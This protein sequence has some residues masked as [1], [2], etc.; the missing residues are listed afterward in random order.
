M[1]STSA[2]EANVP[3][4][5][6]DP[7]EAPLVGRSLVEASAGTGKTYAITTLLLRLVVEEGL[8]LERVL[9]V[10]FTEAAT[11]ELRDR[12]RR[13]L[14]EALLAF[15][16]GDA[17]GDPALAALLDRC[18]DREQGRRR[19]AVASQSVDLASIS[20][21][22]GFCH[23]VL[24]DSAFDSG[25][26]FDL[27]VVADLQTLRDE[28]ISDHW[29]RRV[30]ADPTPL[31][32]ALAAHGVRPRV[33]RGLVERAISNP[34]LQI[35][36]AVAAE[37]ADDAWR[38]SFA[39]ALAQARAAWDESAVLQCLSGPQLYKSR[40][41]RDELP[42]WC[43][44][45][46]RYLKDPPDTPVLPE[47][48][49]K[50]GA[51]SMAK[52]VYKGQ[53][54][55]EHPFFGAVDRLQAASTEFAA[56]AREQAIAFQHDLVEW[57]RFEVP[58]RAEE[59]GVLSFDDLL[60]QVRAA[61]RGRSGE[62]LARRL[63][64]RWPAALV[65]EFQDTDPIQ[66][67]IVDRAFGASRLFLVGDPKQAIYSFRGADV[68]AYLRAVDATPVERRFTM[69]HNWRS[70][71]TLVA[72][73]NRLFVRSGGP[74]PPFLIDGIGYPEVTAQ[75]NAVDQLCAPEPW[76]SA[77]FEILFQPRPGSGDGKD[78]KDSKIDR[79]YASRQVPPLVATEIRG[80]LDSGASVGER[81]LTA[82]D[83]AVLT[84]T[85]QQAFDVQDAL[86]DVGIKSV[87]LGDKSVFGSAEAEELHRVLR[88]VAEPTNTAA[89]RAA[90]TT[91]LFG[92]VANDLEAMED[93]G[94]A[95]EGWVR[96][97]RDWNALWV[98]RGFVQMFRAMVAGR[99]VQERL[100]RFAD[101]ERR[102]TNLLHL[103]ELLHTASRNE[104]LGPVGL[105]H[106]FATQRGLEGYASEAAQ[107]R[108]ESDE[109]AVRITTVHRA[110]GLEYDVVYCP[111]LWDGWL[112]HPA[113]RRALPFHDPDGALTVDIDPERRD[114]SPAKRVA[115]N[116]KLAES[117]R[118]LYVA[119]TRARHRC[120]VLWG[121]YSG[122]ATSA[123][124]Y[125]LHPPKAWP[126]TEADAAVL[127]SHLQALSDGEIREH[128]EAVVAAS[129]GGIAV[130]ELAV[131][132]AERA[133]A[134]G[135]S[136]GAGGAAANATLAARP[137]RR[138]LDR[139]PRLA[140]FTQMV[141]GAPAEEAAER[142]DAA[143]ATAELVAAAAAADQRGPTV[144]LAGMPRG[145]RVGNFF[146]DVLEHLDFA[147]E[148]PAV[149]AVVDDKLRSH[150]LA[151]DEWGAAACQ[152]VRDVL[153]TPLDLD[154]RP[155]RLCDVPAAQRHAELAFHLPVSLAGDDAPALQPRR[156]AVPFAQHPSEALP[157][158]YA[159][160]L[161]Q[162]GFPAIRG[163]LK[164]FIDLLFAVDGRFYVVDYKT[165][166]LGEQQED[167]ARARLTDAM[168][169]GDYFLQYHLYGVAVHRHLARTVPAY[170]YD[171]NFGGA[172]YLFVRG[173]T[174]AR[175]MATGVFFERPPRARIEALS[176]VLDGRDA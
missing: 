159:E 112:L 13:R 2:S 106:W 141:R 111:Y 72:A 133:S 73:V 115:E 151:P 12:V 55:P 122:S 80:L 156:L 130:R 136:G 35:A 3:L 94:A 152:G 134:V 155:T 65:D 59:R 171:R 146:H 175:G 8:E 14:R 63:S 161:A 57:A 147:A 15:S 166:F 132:P 71:P 118:L 34:D 31:A 99:A 87:V 109:R 119:V 78:A 66:Y 17:G 41:P 23:R 29:L 100:L 162:L 45:V 40:Y 58:R 174:P 163:F 108:L 20:T 104:H 28:V 157:R 150:G 49:S 76:G 54:A 33:T 86:R 69:P 125:A 44:T 42:L 67:E 145:A 52:A 142:D 51:R 79:G 137:R 167:Y 148:A 48:L 81:R 47:S 18:E 9:V 26:R 169:H 117:L 165:T 30:C 116:E 25:A 32:A 90:L 173:M 95:W 37:D 105:L 121:A 16:A 113:D 61:L 60:L 6:F 39:T 143:A 77:P 127:E 138:T 154:G 153:D 140:S 139:G 4:Q 22:H 91:E 74:R 82:A 110:K 11:A 114:S 164:G 84:R 126:G 10:T 97:F 24:R 19:L 36:P 144:V 170:D 158:D 53:S 62:A 83:V 172:L 149:A 160:R 168:V 70:G 75:P 38:A 124:G 98:G 88:S 92:V 120:T 7:I 56:R 129:A 27:E 103:M 96:D 102:M 21:I 50:L 128:L 101:G 93:D 1:T 131:D 123:L 135:A 46:T 85:N 5:P 89:L 176:A 68:F 64:A 107:I 43:A